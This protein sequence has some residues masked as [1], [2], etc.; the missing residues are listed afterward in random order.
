M[1]TTYTVNC[2]KPYQL[3]TAVASH[4]S[5]SLIDSLLKSGNDPNVEIRYVTITYADH[6]DCVL[7]STKPTLN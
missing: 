1:Y 6:V 2:I 3:Y 4:T 5:I 7:P